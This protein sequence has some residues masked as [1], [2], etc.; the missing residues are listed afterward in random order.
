MYIKVYVLD[1]PIFRIKLLYFITF[2][3]IKFFF[4]I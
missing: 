3:L 1:Y 2:N 4:Y